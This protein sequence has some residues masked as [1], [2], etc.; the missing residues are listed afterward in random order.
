MQQEL[1][2]GPGVGLRP[3]EGAADAELPA[4]VRQGMGTE[5]PRAAGQRQR[6]DDAVPRPR[7]PGEPRLAPKER[8]V[9]RRVV[10]D[11]RVVGQEV[12]DPRQEVREGRGARHHLVGDPVHG[13]SAGVDGTQGVDQRHEGVDHRSAQETEQG[14]LADPVTVGRGKPRGLHVRRDERDF[15]DAGGNA[16]RHPQGSPPLW[17]KIRII[18]RETPDEKVEVH[19]LRLHPPGRRASCN[20]P[21][22]RGAPREVRPGLMP[23]ARGKVALVTGG[24][25]RIGAAISRA[26]A[27]AGYT[28]VLRGPFLLTRA[29]LPLLRE[30][31]GGAGVLFLGDAFAGELWPGYLP[32]CLSKLDRKST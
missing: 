12:E 19:G 8:Q 7:S 14:D 9:E 5:S 26:L 4:D 22:L 28:V 10:E 29:L 32:Y 18:P 21:H 20:L 6:I 1:P 30:S 25:R 15:D 24:S 3:V 23:E 31:P 16:D 13:G 2:R 27:K 17:Y 11:E